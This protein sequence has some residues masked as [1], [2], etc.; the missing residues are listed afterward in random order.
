MMCPAGMKG[1]CIGCCCKT[2]GPDP[3][4]EA[5]RDLLQRHVGPTEGIDRRWI[6]DI[7]YIAICEGGAY[8]ASAFDLASRNVVGRTP[9]GHMRTEL[10]DRV[11]NEE[12]RHCRRARPK[13]RPS[14]A[15]NAPGAVS[16]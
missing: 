3:E 1:R 4:A 2:T 8:L 13:P 5:A 12:R 9:A 14:G 10:V 15:A 11:G 16:G 6:G 7:G